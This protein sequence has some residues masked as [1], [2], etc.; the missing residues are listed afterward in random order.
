MITQLKND[1]ITIE[2]NSLGAELWSIKKANETYEYLWQGDAEFWT[3]RSP[4]LFPCVGAVKNGRMIVDGK[5][6]EL[7]NH[8]FAR[9][10]EFQLVKEDSN[11]LVYVFKFD[12]RTLSMYPYKFELQL[13]YTI[14]GTN[15]IIGYEVVN[16]DNQ[17]I[18]FQIGTHPGFYCPMAEHLKLD[19]YY[20]AFNKEES[21]RRLFFDD[22][23][24]LVSSKDEAG[25]SG[26]TMS[27]SHDL[28][29]EGATI[30]RDMNSTE[31][32]LKSDQDS[33]FVKLSYTKMPYLGVWQTSDAPYLCIEP[34]HGISD[35]DNY[36]GD[37]IKKEMMIELPVNKKYN[38]QLKISL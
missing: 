2:V 34:W 16:L 26:K 7:G 4:V 25:L 3:G 36:S 10:S 14:E 19:D 27:L 12:E 32:T 5:T 29:Y 28:F 17:S 31:V 6:Y 33:R 38:C 15:V 22:A 35:E 1:D 18:Y 30:F 9:K 23:N 21:S 24:L 8:G 13:T 11:S 37:F 20:L